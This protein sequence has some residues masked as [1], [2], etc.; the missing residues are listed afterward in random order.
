MSFGRQEDRNDE[1]ASQTRR[2][3]RDAAAAC[4]RAPTLRCWRAVFRPRAGRID[5]HRPDELPHYNADIQAGVFP[6]KV[7]SLGEAVTNASGIILLTP[8]YNYSI[9][10][11]LKNVLDWV[12]RLSR[13]PFQGKPV[14]IQTAS[15]GV[16]GGIRAQYHL[17]QILVFLDALPMN[18]PE[19]VIGSVGTKISDGQLTDQATRDFLGS[20]LADFA[21]FI[22][23]HCRPW[24]TVMSAPG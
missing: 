10:G 13:A 22:E 12:S 8:E 19:V 14:A 11:F 24:S 7:L 1:E 2:D 20:Q 3:R 5:R 16:L 4:A 18:K 6:D 15:A 23:R 17:R 21:L 9:P